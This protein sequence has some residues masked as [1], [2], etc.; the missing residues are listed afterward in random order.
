MVMLM[1]YYIVYTVSR[2]FCLVYI[3]PG[4]VTLMGR[5]L[6]STVNASAAFCRFKVNS[7]II[8][9]GKS[10]TLYSVDGHITLGCKILCSS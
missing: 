8:I 9:Y 7:L 10:C 6:N 2:E 1:Y 3:A 4:V 5:G